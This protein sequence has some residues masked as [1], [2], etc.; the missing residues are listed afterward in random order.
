M[1]QEMRD[2]VNDI[3]GIIFI[4]LKKLKLVLRPRAM[5][6]HESL[7]SWNLKVFF[8]FL[9]CSQLPIA[10]R[11][12]NRR[13]V[14]FWV[15]IIDSKLTQHVN[16]LIHQKEKGKKNGFQEKKRDKKVFTSI[17]K[18]STIKRRKKNGRLSPKITVLTS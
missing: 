11:Y 9:S 12:A 16:F 3:F 15:K 10:Y 13:K 1:K 18:F 6:T 8:L 2:N 7:H 14:I 5:R 4:F 17:R